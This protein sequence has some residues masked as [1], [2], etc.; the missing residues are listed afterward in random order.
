[1][2]P[3]AAEQCS[4]LSWARW[5]LSSA[6]KHQMGLS[7]C[8]VLEKDECLRKKLCKNKGGV[9]Q[10]LCSKK[11]KTQLA[12]VSY[13]RFVDA[14]GSSG[15]HSLFFPRGVA[16]RI[17]SMSFP[18]LEFATRLYFH[19]RCVSKYRLGKRRCTSWT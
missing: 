16:F 8:S 3:S 11:A 15:R 2:A 9:E 19:P 10:R 18:P 12:S 1:M 4:A 5:E 6:E 17:A 7:S 13:K 14:V